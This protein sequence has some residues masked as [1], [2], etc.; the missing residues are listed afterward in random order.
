RY[1]IVAP[2]ASGGMGKVYRARHLLSERVVALKVLE[3]QAAALGDAMARFRQEASAAANVGHDGIVDVL[4]A[5]I[6]HETGSPFIA[7]ELLVGEDLRELLRR[8]PQQ[9]FASILEALHPLA[10]LHA[11]G[12]V[13]RDLKPENIFSSRAPGGQQAV[14]I[15]DFGI[16]R[17]A[18]VDAH[19]RT[20]ASLGTP[21][22]M[23]PEQIQ[24]ARH[25]SAAS[26]VWAVGVMLYEAIA[27][28]IPFEGP[29]SHAVMIDACRRPHRPLVEIASV[30]PQLSRIIDDCL[31]KD[32][33]ER[34]PH[35]GD[36]R[37]S[38]AALG[39]LT[40]PD[41]E[42]VISTHQ[43]TLASDSPVDSN[44]DPTG[45]TMG[46]S[47]AHAPTELSEPPGARTTAAVVNTRPPAVAEPSRG[48]WHWVGASVAV[49]M[50]VGA[51]AYA[52]ARPPDAPL[53]LL[54]AGLE[55]RLANP[56]P[57]A[58]GDQRVSKLDWSLDLPADWAPILGQLPA[59]IQ[60]QAKATKGEWAM[61]PQINVQV[62][63]YNQP[64]QTYVILGE[65]NMEAGGATIHERFRDPVGVLDGA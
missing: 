64:L 14:K 62:D 49:L 6:C 48:R 58:E 41:R 37:E 53:T 54:Q 35:A 21:G 23:A 20:G 51:G 8:D 3:P 18:E 45:P 10:A 4:D 16:A 44:V 63:A 57:P 61:T 52:L 1:E 2:L 65:H 5:G 56:S 13:H 27:G 31:A 24:S 50:G 34:P 32:P 46:A 55:R 28:R 12:F 25:A 42:A 39:L 15:L 36:L 30:D 26:D 11:R 43:P 19:T 60:L 7:M 38:L 40:I 33:T 47:L 22:Y 59:N 29:T 9:A 17:S